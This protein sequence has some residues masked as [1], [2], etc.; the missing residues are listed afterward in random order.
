MLD[1]NIKNYRKLLVYIYTH[2]PFPF[3]E[4]DWL[5]FVTNSW[6]N[7]P[8]A[9]KLECDIQNIKLF[10]VNA[11]LNLIKEEAEYVGIFGYRRYPLFINHFH[12]AE[13]RFYL[14]PTPELME[15]LAS[16]E[17]ADIALHIL[18]SHDVI[19]FRP[20]PLGMNVRE[21]FT[22]YKPKQVWDIIIEEFSKLGLRS[23]LGYLEHNNAHVWTSSFITH[24]QIAADY[25]KFVL[26][27]VFRLNQRDD[28]KKIADLQEFASASKSIHPLHEWAVELSTPLWFFHHRFKSAYVPMVCLEK[29][30]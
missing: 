15:K 4:A 10:W 26:D 23:S 12:H 24:R 29:N 19:Q 27:L 20:Y 3:H 9:E 22:F 25:A 28:F 5:K 6:D 18:E 16:Q 2:R 7:V 14:D 13:P 21:Q 8:N 1:K 11:L 30:A 17:Q